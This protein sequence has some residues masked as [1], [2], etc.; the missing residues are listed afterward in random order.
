MGHTVV[1]SPAMPLLYHVHSVTYS[2]TH[3]LTARPCSNCCL[4]STEPDLG[5]GDGP[6]GTAPPSFFRD[7]RAG[8]I[9]YRLASLSSET[10]VRGK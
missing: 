5:S 3:T 10:K 7:K 6:F 4:S 8:A 2:H 1:T 9:P